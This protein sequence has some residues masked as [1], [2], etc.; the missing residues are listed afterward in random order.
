MALSR[1][2]SARRSCDICMNA[3]FV[4]CFVFMLYVYMCFNVFLTATP[5][6]M[7]SEVLVK[8]LH[9][10]ITSI[11]SLTFLCVCFS[12]HVLSYIE[13]NFRFVSYNTRLN[14]LT[15]SAKKRR[16]DSVN[17]VLLLLSYFL[18][19]ESYFVIFLPVEF[20]YV[21]LDTRRITKKTV[22]VV[23]MFHGTVSTASCAFIHLGY[24]TTVYCYRFPFE[25]LAIWICIMHLAL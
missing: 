20:C 18:I 5:T 12:V 23:K 4:F 19:F 16:Y 10:D 15:V 3:N 14:T 6:Y 21:D 22:I 25:I 7:R 8:R 1:H 2:S 13:L 24:T 17:L 9:I 11:L